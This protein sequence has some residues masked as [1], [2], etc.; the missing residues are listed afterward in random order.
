MLWWPLQ[1]GVEIACARTQFA[2]PST[3]FERR[4]C[5]PFGRMPLMVHSKAGGPPFFTASKKVATARR[6]RCAKWTEDAT[7]GDVGNMAIDARN[8]GADSL[9]VCYPTVSDV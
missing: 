9:G 4:R 6:G 1:K 7:A 8:K 2:G 5:R 3:L